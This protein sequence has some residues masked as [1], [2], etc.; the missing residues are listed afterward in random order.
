MGGCYQVEVMAFFLLEVHHHIGQPFRPHAV[1]Q[2]SLAQ[3]KILTVGAARLAKAEENGACSSRAAD[4][5]F[6][7]TM[8]VPGSHNGF[9]AGPAYTGLARDPIAWAFLGYIQVP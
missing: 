9:S 5:W 4:G 2:P 8:D 7:S 1:S 6:L 3:R